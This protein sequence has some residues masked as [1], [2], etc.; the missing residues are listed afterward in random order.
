MVQRIKVQGG[1]VVY[2]AS[3]PSFD[4]SMD[5]AG[6]VNV[7]KELNVGTISTKDNTD[8]NISPGLN[9]NINL[10][11]SGTGNIILDNV[12]WPTNSPIAGTFLGGTS[13]NTLSFLP[14]I[15]S[16]PAASDNLT[17]SQLDILYPSALAG[18]KVIG[19]NVMYQKISVGNWRTMSAT[20]TAGQAMVINTQAGDYTLQL[21]DAFN[22]LIRITKPTPA[23]VTIENDTVVNMPVG[24]AVLISW[25]GT[26][27]VSIAAGSGVT[28]DTP[29]SYTIG[30]Q[31]GKITAIKVGANHWEIEGNLAP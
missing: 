11:P 8:L 14:F 17:S 27:S 24:S 7:S 21:S 25:N 31:Y 20:S 23:V 26:G 3:D 5:V 12:S 16:P 13:L 22:T 19:P 2:E 28:I 30:K 15:L 9:G 18:Q 6:R 10:N 1:Q 29:D 4:I